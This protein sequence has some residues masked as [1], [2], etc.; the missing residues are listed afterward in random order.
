MKPNMQLG[1]PC[2]TLTYRNYMLLAIL[3]YYV[4]AIYITHTVLT[5]RHNANN[6]YNTNR[7]HFTILTVT[8]NNNCTFLRELQKSIGS[9]TRVDILK[10]VI[11]DSG[12]V[13]QS[14]KD[15]ME[16]IVITTDYVARFR[17]PKNGIANARSY[18]LSLVDTPYF[19]FL[20]DDDLISPTAVEL[21]LLFLVV[22][23]K[24]II[25]NNKLQ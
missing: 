16:E 22:T 4:F 21:Y 14:S 19:A 1:F 24:I 10:W 17:S 2:F 20:D 23:F 9:Q 5:K 13:F 18:A 7:K 11:I 15:C 25:S 12:T 3:V 6:A 8:K